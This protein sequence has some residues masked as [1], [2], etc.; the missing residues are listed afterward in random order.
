MGACAPIV[1]CRGMST[2]IDDLVDATP[3]TRDR[4]VDFLRALSIS[5]VVLWHWVFS[6]T[7]W[8]GDGALTMPNPLAGVPFLWLL[9]WVLQIMPLFFFV[10]GFANFVSY[11]AHR[12]K[13]GSDRDFVRSRLARLGKPIG[14][15]LA[16][17]M[18][19]EILMH[20][21][22]SGYPGVLRWG[23]V[24]FVPLWFMAVYGTVVALAPLIIRLHE[25]S[26]GGALA[27]LGAGVV[28]VDTV[29]FSFG[30][31]AIGFINIL[32]VFAFV[33]QLGYFY[34]DGTLTR[35]SRRVHWA[36]ALG[37]FGALAVLTTFGPYA[38]SMVAMDGEAISNMMPP[39]VC[40]AALGVFQAGLALLLR[41]ALNRL[42]QRRKPWKLV[43]AA[44][45]TAMTV[46]AWHMTAYV[47]AVGT[48][49]LLG[50]RLRDHVSVGWWAERPLWLLLPGAFLAGCIALFGRFEL[51]RR[52]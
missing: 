24:V 8:N 43:V 38:R 17:W 11:T 27:V 18:G 14:V 47:L 16:I 51:G 41:P 31:D 13:G 21:A 48:V 6:V 52:G 30:I 20:L 12:R 50:H 10:G 28:L 22:S 9:T 44:N 42:C 29:R 33:H 3:S 1:E 39:N 35:C 23:F 15:F 7:H 49:A 36:L 25:R 37:G 45:A 26:R 5:V 2:T 46:F 34:G 19:F 32:V 4:S 40:I